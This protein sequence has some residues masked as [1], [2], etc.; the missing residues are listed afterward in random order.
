MSASNDPSP[1]ASNVIAPFKTS[2]LS[3]PPRPQISKSYLLSEG[4]LRISFLQFI[5]TS[6]KKFI[7]SFQHHQIFTEV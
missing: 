3:P 7:S 4:V 2:Y 1:Q 5:I 6:L